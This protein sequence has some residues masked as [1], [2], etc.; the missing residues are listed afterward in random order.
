PALSCVSTMTGNTYNVGRCV[1]EKMQVEC[2]NWF[3]F[4][5][6]RNDG[7]RNH[8]PREERARAVAVGWANVRKRARVTDCRWPTRQIGMLSPK[9]GLRTSRRPGGAVCF[10]I[11]HELGF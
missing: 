10:R 5:T 9:A 4:P 2:K 8:L 3:V 11:V 7:L 6:C 1:I